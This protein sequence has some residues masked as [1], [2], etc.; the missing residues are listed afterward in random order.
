MNRETLRKLLPRFNSQRILVLGDFMLDEFLWG[1]VD[2]IS[3]EAPVPV[4]DVERETFA[5]GGAGN[6]VMNVKVLGGQPVP[7]GIAGDDVAGDRIRKLLAQSGI[8]STSLLQAHRPTTVKTR[9]LAHQQQVVRVD[10]EERTFID[11]ALR[12]AVCETFLRLLPQVDGVLISDY[13]KGTLSP[14]L[15]A[16]IL[17][18]ARQ[19]GKLV[20]LD[21]KIRHFSSYTP[22]TVIT[23]NQAEASS[24]LG[25]PIVTH[26]D[27]EEA[28]RRILKLIDCKALLVTRGEKGMALFENGALTLVPTRAREVYDVTG[29]GDTVIAALCLALAAGAAMLPAVELANIA[30]GIVVG[31][32]GTAAVSP[33]EL[34]EV[35]PE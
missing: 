20:C 12:D 32:V 27:L 30:A 29:A 22:L 16:R 14:E 28:G 7:L 10:R 9:I 2:R 4:V 8:D 18:A 1:R 13:S 25:Y 17:P 19:S 24:L 6:V 33:A 26:E 11:A 15:L 3:P 34:I 23:P 21:P 5:L 35:T 31:K